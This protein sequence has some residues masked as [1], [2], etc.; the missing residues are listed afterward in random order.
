VPGNNNFLVTE[1]KG[2]LF[3]SCDR[4]MSGGWRR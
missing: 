2:G 4:L 1:P 3:G